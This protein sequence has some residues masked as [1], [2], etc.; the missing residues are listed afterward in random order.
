MRH[1]HYRGYGLKHAR[2]CQDVEQC[3]GDVLCVGGASL[4]LWPMP[5]EVGAPQL[6]YSCTKLAYGEALRST[7][8]QPAVTGGGIALRTVYTTE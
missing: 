6:D 3:G 8:T 7:V 2:C 1:R 4:P 5:Y